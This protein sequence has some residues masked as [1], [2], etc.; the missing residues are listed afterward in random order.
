M[1]RHA[2]MAPLPRAEG[3]AEG[4]RCLM[5]IPS[6]EHPLPTLPLKGEEFL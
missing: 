1:M 6:A 4:V 2:I 5:I 3:L